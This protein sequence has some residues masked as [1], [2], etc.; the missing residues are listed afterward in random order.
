MRWYAAERSFA[1]EGHA[2]GDSELCQ[3]G[4]N[5]EFHCA[6]RNV[7]FRG[8][9]L[10]RAALKNAV[11]NF[12]LATADLHS[13]SEGTPRSQKFL[14]PLRGSVQKRLSAN[15]HQFVILRR[16][17]SHQAMHGEQTGNFFHRHAAIGVSLHTKPHSPRGTLA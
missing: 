14:S 8:N 10:V 3:Q 12:L 17:A 5:V 9:F 15:D 6:F 11:Q 1:A 16:L 2:I 7:E 13:C 4:R